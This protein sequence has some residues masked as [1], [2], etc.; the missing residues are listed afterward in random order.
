[1]NKKAKILSKVKI[2]FLK[3]QV[4]SELTKFAEVLWDKANR[5]KKRVKVG[6]WSLR[7]LLPSL[8][9]RR[10]RVRGGREGKSKV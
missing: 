1:M 10:R 2:L 9:I 7:Q 4:K 6:S 3:T 5:V 8:A